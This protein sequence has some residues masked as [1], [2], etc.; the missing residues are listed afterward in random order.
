MSNLQK[1]RIPFSEWGVVKPTMPL[2]QVPVL[3]IDGT[4]MTQSTSLYRYCAKCVDLYPSEPFQALVVD[5]TMDIVNDLITRLP[6]RAATDEEL[7]IQRHKHRDTFMKE[8]LRLIEARI[9][10]YSSGTNTICGTPSVA[11]LFLMAYKN[12]IDSNAFPH[13]D[14]TIFNDYPRILDVSNNIMKHPIV[15]SYYNNDKN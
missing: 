10:Q 3:S 13:L 6:K 4:E 9:E 15:K 5:E 14:G 7:K 1:T 12:T 11:D 2:G 8:G